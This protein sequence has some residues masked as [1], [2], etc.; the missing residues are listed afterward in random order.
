[1]T[2]S[3]L[4]PL[5]PHLEYGTK[6]ILG[7]ATSLITR[8]RHLSMITN[9]AYSQQRRVRTDLTVVLNA[10]AGQ[11]DVDLVTQ[12]PWLKSP[13]LQNVTVSQPMPLQCPPISHCNTSF[14]STLKPSSF[15]RAHPYSVQ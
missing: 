1:M 12:T 9:R 7:L 5:R 6:R 2:D 15:T 3:H 10:F 13:P 4:L 14:E 11:L 8:R